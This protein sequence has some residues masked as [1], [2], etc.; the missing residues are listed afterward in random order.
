[1]LLYYTLQ[2]NKITALAIVAIVF[3]TGT[4]H[5]GSQEIRPLEPEAPEALFQAEVGSADVSLFAQGS[6]KLS[7]LAGATFGFSSFGELGSVPSFPEFANGLEFEQEP[8]LTISLWFLKRYFFET[9]IENTEETIE[10]K[11]FLLGYRGKEE[12][13]LRYVLVGN[14]D[15]T[16]SPHRFLEIPQSTETSPGIA[17][18]FQSPTNTHEFLLRYDPSG[19]AKKKYV[20]RNEVTEERIAL[21]AF[22]RGRFF[23]LPDAGVEG[24]RVY[25]EDR[26][27]TITGSDGNRYAV[28]D[29]TTASVDSA[30]GFVSLRTKA[31]GRVLVYYTKNGLA[32]GDPSLGKAFLPAVTGG[33][34]D[35]E[36]QPTDFSWDA[37]FMGNPMTDRKV[38]IEGSE[39]LMVYEPGSFSPFEVMNA[40]APSFSIPKEDY[41][42]IMY[43]VKKG[44]DTEKTG[45][46]YYFTMDSENQRIVVY[47][48]SSEIRSVKNRYPF[49]SP[50]PSI[51]EG[52]E[53][54]ELLQEEIYAAVLK[55]TSLYTLPAKVVPGSVRITRNGMDETRYVVDYDTGIITFH[56]Y[57]YP[58]DELEISYSTSESATAGGDV[59]F[60]TGHSLVLADGLRLDVAAGLRWSLRQG[61]YSETPK[62]HPGAAVASAGLHYENDSIKALFDVGV[63]YATPDS[64]G[65]LRL[66]GM[67]ATGIT[68]PMSGENVFPSS[69]PFSPID[70]ISLTRANRGKLLFRDYRLYQAFGQSVLMPYTWTAFPAEQAVPYEAGRKPGPYT[71]LSDDQSGA[72][73]ILVMEYSMTEEQKWIGAQ[74]PVV[75]GSAPDLSGMTSLS[76]L[77]RMPESNGTVK[78]FVQVGAVSEDLDGDGVLDAETAA[79]DTGYSFD[80]PAN[81][82]QLYVGGG[83]KEK[84]N[85]IL[86]SEDKDVNGLLDTDVDYLLVTKELTGLSDAWARA[87]IVLTDAERRRLSLCRAV[88]IIV[89]NEDGTTKSGKILVSPIR[90]QGAGFT[91]KIDSPGTIRIRELSEA[92]TSSPLPSAEQLDKVFPEVASVYHPNG[93]AQRILEV[94]WSGL[95]AGGTAKVEAFTPAVPMRFYNTLSWYMRIPQL[96]DSSGTVSFSYTDSDG[97]GI[98]FKFKPGV[99]SAWT[100]F[101][102]AIDTKILTANGHAMAAEV[103]VDADAGKLSRF[104]VMLADSAAGLLYLDEVVLTDPVGSVGAGASLKFQYAYRDA[105]IA[106]G[107]VTLLGNVSFTEEASVAS[108]GFASQYGDIAESASFKSQSVLEADVL[109]T[110]LRAEFSVQALESGVSM[111]GSHVLKVPAMPSPVIF[112]DSFSLG[113]DGRT[114]SRENALIVNGDQLLSVKLGTDATIGKEAF[115]QTWYLESVSLWEV[116]VRLQVKGKVARERSSFP[117]EEGN[118]FSRWISAYRFYA[119]TY[120]GVFSK[121]SASF[122]LK[123]DM[124]PQPVGFSLEPTLGFESLKLEGRRQKNSGGLSVALPIAF[125]EPEEWRLSVA[126]GR[127]FSFTRSFTYEG[128]VGEDFVALGEDLGTKLFIYSSIPLADLFMPQVADEFAEGT[129]GYA[130]GTYNPTVSLSLSRASGSYIANLFLPSFG[131]AR[132]QRKISR[133][134]DTI[135]DA[136][137]WDLMIKNSAIN[138]F[139]TYGSSPLFPFYT[140]DEFVFYCKFIGESKN[141]GS[142]HIVQS[143][144]G[145]YLMFEKE[146]GNSVSLDNTVSFTIGGT[147]WSEKAKLTFAWTSKLP[148]SFVL[149]I[150]GEEIAKDSYFQHKEILRIET[151]Q[152]EE[153]TRGPGFL[154]AVRHETSLVVAK[155]GYLKGSFDLG[156]QNLPES[157]GTLIG[158]MNIIGIQGGIEAQVKF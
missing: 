42:S 135:L 63:S 5:L 113:T 20:G 21:N 145:Q 16:I 133:E 157:S 107:D 89:L 131:E 122:S 86:D 143:V 75:G 96:G 158:R 58:Q 141:V 99:I 149:P 138:L 147:A 91:S 33:H 35:P 15:I 130:A 10:L 93:E 127:N 98:Q 139:G 26:N 120:E 80:D 56:T 154:L 90:F 128:D 53:I 155:W 31:A 102:L 49:G 121:R 73:E 71:A 137:S 79:S 62:E 134:G 55:E 92:E 116:P 30:G 57:I 40:Y 95:P 144:L 67:E 132:I 9:V 84:G 70:G 110:R 100:K 27:G 114:M 76:F 118:Y 152:T 126:Y 115:A 68:V 151:G 64:T 94:S 142:P 6:W 104:S 129:T 72:T 77:V 156:W 103:T 85:S 1:M 124:S 60:A 29:A 105:I 81:G 65:R 83:P 41:S 39:A 78:V 87:E 2:V 109:L 38:I 82:V 146:K 32:L 140:V 19:R 34:I 28:A 69:I 46:S 7:F 45:Q 44:S 59:L 23:Q 97:K 106:A 12:E 17:A 88:R 150:V 37:V 4:M 24:L 11:T 14:K 153:E 101:S 112:V 51:Y 50:Y 148:G 8:E 22:L 48:D 13:F 108:E 61:G 47:K 111:Q 66:F 117:F 74:V 18:K 25:L 125:A 36:S 119:L 3:C 54:K 52:G 123:T 136:F 43:L